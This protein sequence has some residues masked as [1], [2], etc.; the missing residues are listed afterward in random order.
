M[1]NLRRRKSTPVIDQL[2]QLVPGLWIYDSKTRRWVFEDGSFVVPVS[3][4]HEEHCFTQW[5]RYFESDRAPE[6]LVI[7][8]A[9]P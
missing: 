4:G 6:P 9:A 1:K 5:W 7:L 2:R 3:V 8:E